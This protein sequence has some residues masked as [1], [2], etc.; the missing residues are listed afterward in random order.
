MVDF[1]PWPKIPRLSK[2]RKCIITEKID[3][4]NASIYIDEDSQLIHAGSRKR[5]LSKENDNFGF[6]KWAFAN[7]SELQKLGPGHHF[8]EWY[9]SGI[10]RGYGLKNGEKRFSLFN[11]G[12][13]QQVYQATIEGHT[14][15][16]PSCCS[17]VPILAEEIFSDGL[18]VSRLRNL[19][20]NGSY[21]VPG[22]M[23]PEGIIIYMCNE[24]ALYKH[25][26]DHIEGKWKDETTKA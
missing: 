21:A 20:L 22:Y 1:T 7:A 6:Y 24:R 25:T 14:D 17:V 5:W 16:F 2:E 11:A 18:V 10:Q 15:A 4:T 8:G 23:N 12:R 3:G 26:F 13:W 9:G 19:S